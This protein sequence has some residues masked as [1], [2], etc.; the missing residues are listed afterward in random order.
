MG[1][2]VPGTPGTRLSRWGT[3]IKFNCLL[4]LL[5]VHRVLHQACLLL[6]YFVCCLFWSH[7]GYCIK[8]VYCCFILFVVSSGHTWGTTSSLFIV[9]SFCLLSLLVTR[10]T[11]SSMFVVVLFC[12]LSLLVTH[13]VLHQACLLF[14]LVAGGI[15]Y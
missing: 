1:S 14:L 2:L 15:L 13:E 9:V 5:V 11:A 8:L 6:F 3:D 10:G 7:M 12:L 4:F